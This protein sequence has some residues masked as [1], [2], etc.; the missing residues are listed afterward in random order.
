MSDPS[1]R[2]E[3]TSDTNREVRHSNPDPDPDPDPDQNMEARTDDRGR[4]DDPERAQTGEEA[5]R[6]SAA[7]GP[8][9]PGPGPSAPSGG[10]DS[11]VL[12]LLSGIV[13]LVGA[14]I[15]ASPFVYGATDVALWNN[16][17]VG[18]AI[19]VLAGY[20]FY[21]MTDDQPANVGGS[22]LVALLGLWSV[23]APFLLGFGAEGLVWSTMA[24]GAAVA[25]LSGYNA[26]ETRRTG[27][28]TTTGTRA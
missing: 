20:N 12:K 15:A 2:D 5:A 22:S 19:L 10:T 8:G 21:R 24:S 16:V 25:V 3:T 13:A 28:T 17:A 18:G 14:W 4:R 1:D 26:Y 7:R 11:D 23:V 27:T 6:E 9:E